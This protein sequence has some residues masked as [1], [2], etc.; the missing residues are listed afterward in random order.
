MTV[1]TPKNNIR[2]IF[3]KYIRTIVIF[4]VVSV[5][6]NISVSA[7][8]LQASITV[9]DTSEQNLAPIS[10]LMYGGFVEYLDDEINHI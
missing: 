4:F 3:T 9:S 2:Y 1:K 6:G 7:Q 10:P 5:T 8:M